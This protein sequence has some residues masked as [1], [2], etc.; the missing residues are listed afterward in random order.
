MLGIEWHKG[1]KIELL[2]VM[3]G[4]GEMYLLIKPNRHLHCL[5]GHLYQLSIVPVDSIE[6]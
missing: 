3:V 4:G 2:M 1:E 6:H 5:F